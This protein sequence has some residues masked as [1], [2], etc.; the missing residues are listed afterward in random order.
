ML[1]LLKQDDIRW[2][3]LI[4]GNGDVSMAKKGCLVA[5]VCMANL[6]VGNRLFPDKLTVL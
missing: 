1:E 3:E 4:F 6:F 2:G 5:C